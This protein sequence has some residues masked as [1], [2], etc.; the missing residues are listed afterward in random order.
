MELGLT[1]YDSKV[2]ISLLKI[3]TSPVG[4]IYRHSGVPRNKIYGSL[5]S[6][7]DKGLIEVIP[8]IPKKYAFKEVD[9]LYGLL[10]KEEERLK[11]LRNGIEHL[12]KIESKIGKDKAQ[13]WINYGTPAFK[14]KVKASLKKTRKENFVIITKFKM[15]PVVLRLTKEAIHR[16][17]KIK[18]LVSAVDANFVKTWQEAG[19]KI[20]KTLN[21]PEFGFATYDNFLCRINLENEGKNDVT[22][23]IESP[24]FVNF[25]RERFYSL[26]KKSKNVLT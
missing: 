14:E 7:M 1:E 13:L 18:F 24:A 3:G 4:E 16:G 22:L 2:L 23:W 26:W 19:V 6:L 10:S 8:S 12:K 21:C 17:T 9:A 11:L 25:L 5:R 15:D 20:R